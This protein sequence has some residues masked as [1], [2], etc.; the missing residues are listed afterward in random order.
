MSTTLL[1]TLTLFSLLKGNIEIPAYIYIC[2]NSLN[3]GH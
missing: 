1:T 2:L 3:L